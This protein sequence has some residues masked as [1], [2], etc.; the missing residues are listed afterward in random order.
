MLERTQLMLDRDTKEGLRALSRKRNKSI[1]HVARDVLSKEIEKE[2]GTKKHKKNPKK[3]FDEI[4]KH[5]MDLGITG[6]YDKY[7]YHV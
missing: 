6:D 5:S 2:F 1:S 4:L 3:F 7:I